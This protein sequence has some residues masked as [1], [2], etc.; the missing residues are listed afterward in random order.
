LDGADEITIPAGNGI[1]LKGNLT[2]PSES[3][4]LV[5]FSHGSGSSRMSRRNKHVAEILNKEKIATLLTD[6]LTEK[7]D[8]IYENR[9]DI[10]LLTERLVNV[11]NYVMQIPPL[12]NLKV[13]YF[14]ASTGA[15]SALKAAARIHDT[16]HAVVSRGGRPDLAKEDLTEVR[17]PTLLIVGSLDG[18]VIELNQW[19]FN[20]LPN[21]KKLEIVEGAAHLF[22]EPGKLDKVAG[23]AADWFIKYLHPNPSLKT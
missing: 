6:L 12:Q 1:S 2:V 14:G 9:F 15:A 13:G 11:T 7:E 21:E 3:N 17:T 8:A 16:I 22:E 18:T 5:I 23:L 4:A 20:Q 10:D 19:A